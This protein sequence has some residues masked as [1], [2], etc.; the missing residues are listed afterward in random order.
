MAYAT[1]EEI[2]GI[3]KFFDLN[4]TESDVDTDQQLKA[5]RDVNSYLL[6]ELIPL[7]ATDISD[8]LAAAEICFYLENGAMFRQL[9]N[10]FGVV[11]QETRGKW[12][13]KYEN[14][15][16]MFFFAQGAARPFMKL[17]PHET[18]KMQ[19]NRYI[20]AYIQAYNITSSTWEEAYAYGS[21]DNTARGEGWADD[22]S[23]WDDTLQ[24]LD[25]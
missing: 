9:E 5:T 12:T 15:M 25:V 10:A 14:G 23:D 13:K 2:A 16:P 8:M 4:F 6:L 22:V 17:L 19:G 3:M 18:W 24:R 20:D 7:P 11:G 21:E 1:A